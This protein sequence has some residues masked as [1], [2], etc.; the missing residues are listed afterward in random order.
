MLFSTPSITEGTWKN[1][2]LKPDYTRVTVACRV[3]SC[4]ISNIAQNLTV[5]LLI[6]ASALKLRYSQM[7]SCSELNHTLQQ[8]GPHWLSPTQNRTFPPVLSQNHL[9]LSPSSFSSKHIALS[10]PSWRARCC[11]SWI[12]GSVCLQGKV[13]LSTTCSK[14]W[15]CFLAC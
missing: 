7:C 1:T 9:G 11:S 15:K 4:V 6:Y 3:S 8:H 13:Q 14:I 5:H 12:S 10:S 2:Y